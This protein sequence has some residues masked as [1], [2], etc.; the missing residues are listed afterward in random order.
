MPPGLTLRVY[1]AAG[2][3][4]RGIST[5]SREPKAGWQYVFSGVACLCRCCTGMRTTETWS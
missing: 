1:A 2:S 4:K 5:I 3:M